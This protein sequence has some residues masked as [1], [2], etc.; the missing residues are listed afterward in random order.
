VI[1]DMNSGKYFAFDKVGSYL[2]NLLDD[3]LDGDQIASSLAARYHLDSERATQDVQAFLS[4]LTL[5][6]LIEPKLDKAAESDSSTESQSGRKG[7]TDKS[8]ADSHQ[9]HLESFIRVQTRWRSFLSVDAYLTLI[10]TDLGLTT[11]GLQGMWRRFTKS[12]Q[13]HSSTRNPDTVTNLASIALSAFK[14]YRPGIACMHRAFAAYW[15]LR[16]HRI[17]AELCL[18][19]KTCPFSSHAWVEFQGRVLDDSPDV[20][21]RFRVIAKVTSK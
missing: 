12:R 11:L 6:K 8:I 18:G 7:W 10:L 5:M 17:P 16:R 2:W 15:F 9:R 19:V 14:W 21:D 20:K 4:K 1:L 3:A 13:K